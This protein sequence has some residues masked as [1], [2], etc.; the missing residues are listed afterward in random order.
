MLK[1]PQRQ[2]QRTQLG[3]GVGQLSLVEHAL[4]P[5]ESRS[6]L[7]TNLVHSTQYDYTDP[8]RRRLTAN[9]RVFAPLGLS[10]GDELY[11]WG[12]LA[13]TLAQSEPDGCLFATPH[14]CLRQMGLIDATS[15]RGGRQ[16][17]QFAAALQRLSAVSYLSDACYDPTRAEYRRVSFGFLSYSLPA[18]PKSSRA[19]QIS[20]DKV[21]LEMVQATGGSMRFDIQLYRSLDPASRRLFLFLL[22][23]G[24]RQSRLPKF[25]LKRLAVDLL[26]LSPTL[27]VRDMKVKVSRT[28]RRLEAIEVVRQP[29]VLHAA[30][31][32]YTV[33]FERGAYLTSKSA[34]VGSRLTPEE[35]P[36]IDG[37]VAI[38]FDT[39]SAVQL[40]RRFPHHLVSQWTDITQ[41]ALER[42]GQAH[43]RKSPMAFLVDSLSKAA[44]GTRTP[45]DWWHEIRKQEEAAQEP[46]VESRQLF[47]RLIEE[48]FG[49]SSQEATPAKPSSTRNA[50]LVRTGDVLKTAF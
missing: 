42:F 39:P 6:S 23:V 37:L 21:F 25:D 40:V 7:T 38:G 11:L 12:L 8:Q 17:Q 4:C 48:V 44:Q 50:G 16:Y 18:D 27:A 29:A 43:F 2:N 28:L 24:Y 30:P 49:E 34:R 10:S 35:S 41:A 15:R 32:Q 33:V 9:I 36:L 26:G 13:L 19:W 22:K 1:Q 5:L 47:A 46:T 14:W 31:G 3:S 20:W 45:P